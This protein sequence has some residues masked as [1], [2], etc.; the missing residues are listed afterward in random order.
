MAKLTFALAVQLYHWDIEAEKP[1]NS[2]IWVIG[3]DENEVITE[4]STQSGVLRPQNTA[5]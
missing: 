5:F 4:Y 2:R 1:K 3:L